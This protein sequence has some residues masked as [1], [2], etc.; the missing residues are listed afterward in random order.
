MGRVR[1]TETT[2]DKQPTKKR[3]RKNTFDAVTAPHPYG[4]KPSGNLFLAC[5]DTANARARGLGLLA[6]LEDDPVLGILSMVPATTLCC[7]AASS[8]WL[9][10]LAHHDNL[11]RELTL[12]AAI[13]GRVH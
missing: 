12:V 6:A 3:T 11:W 7:L 1:F 10:T 9:Y 5:E 4:A 8:R 13:E 2:L